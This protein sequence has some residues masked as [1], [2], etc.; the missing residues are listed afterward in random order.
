MKLTM[1]SG[2]ARF[3]LLLAGDVVVVVLVAIFVLRPIIGMLNKHTGEITRT[4]AEIAAV[5]QKTSELR[6]LRDTYPAYEAT[7]APLIATL[8][9]TRDV[10]GYQTELEDLAKLT[11]NQLLTVDTSSLSGSAAK[12]APSAA[13]AT[14]PPK[15]DAK[16][17]PTPEPVASGPST[18]LATVA[19]FPAI[20]V[21][22]QLTGTFGSIL[23]F[24]H[25]V[26]T[27]DRFTKVNALDLRANDASGGLKADIQLTT[28][29][30]PGA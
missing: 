16:A 10:A 28:F 27:M 14:P 2:H 25:R 3:Y 13:A 11:S 26:E 19:G 29:Y 9:K 17:T 24:I 1:P 6:K 21:K 30:V 18:T 7:F 15:A 20:P 5:A 12:P 4:K 8:P 23:D 22:V